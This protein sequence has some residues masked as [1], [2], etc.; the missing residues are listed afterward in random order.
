MANAVIA[1]SIALTIGWASHYNPGIFERV[2]EN[3][4][5]WDQISW[6]QARAAEC[7]AAGRY[8]E[9]IGRTI[10]IK[11]DK[12]KIGLEND[13]IPCLIVDV[14][15]I[16]DGGLDWMLSNNVIVEVDPNTML[17]LNG[18]LGGGVKIRATFKKMTKIQKSHKFIMY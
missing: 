6:T 16:A 9:Y 8:P 12:S 1:T 14:A 10:Y 15:G 17:R 3:R 11:R 18:R 4:V 13:W 2:V 5:R 7:Y